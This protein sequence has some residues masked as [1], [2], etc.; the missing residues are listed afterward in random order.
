MLRLLRIKQVKRLI[1]SSSNKRQLA[2]ND[3][4]ISEYIPTDTYSL[5][6]LFPEKRK[7]DNFERMAVLSR[8]GL[9]PLQRSP[10]DILD[11]KIA[12]IGICIHAVIN[13]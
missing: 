9:P 11:E 7:T 1:A 2:T 13:N 3:S 12:M 4:V 5:L 8:L 6:K 10:K